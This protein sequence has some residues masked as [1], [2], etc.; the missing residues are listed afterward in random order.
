MY[1]SVLSGYTAEVLIN[2][3]KPKFGGAPTPLM[4]MRLP[5]FVLILLYPKQAFVSILKN[6][7]VLKFF[8][9]FQQ[10]PIKRDEAIYCVCN[11]QSL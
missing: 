8:E 11:I 6:K 7:F 3:G 2:L 4:N 9:H 10:S 1:V 5:F